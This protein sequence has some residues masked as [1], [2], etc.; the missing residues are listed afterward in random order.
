MSQ[1]ARLSNCRRALRRRSGLKSF[2]SHRKV[3]LTAQRA[4]TASPGLRLE[5]GLVKLCLS[6]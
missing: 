3:H 2:P 1:R 6:E 5:H 4:P